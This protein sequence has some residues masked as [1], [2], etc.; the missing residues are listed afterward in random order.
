MRTA[1]VTVGYVSNER[2]TANE[3][4]DLRAF[5]RAVGHFSGTRALTSTTVERADPEH[6]AE[7]LDPGPSEICT[8]ALAVNAFVDGIQAALVVTHRGHRPVYLNYAAAG[9][10]ALDGSPVALAEDLWVTSS[11]SDREWVDG[12]GSTI[13]I[14]TLEAETP[15][16]VE[17]LGMDSLAGHRSHLERSVVAQLQ[18][19][20][21]AAVVLDGALI[22]RE[23]DRRLFGVV[24]STARK[25]LADEGCLFGLRTGWRSPRFVIPAGPAGSGV[26]R[27]SCYVRLH[28]ASRHHWNFALIRLECFEDPDLLDPLAARCL[29]E[30]QPPTA[31][32]A[33][34]DRHLRS[35]RATEDFLRARRPAVFSMSQ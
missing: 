35:V 3:P 6:P 34:W 30:R 7:V 12:L 22:G 21:A 10:L 20:G 9:A 1:G 31:A 4:H 27:Y 17:R 23:Q 29:L 13:P 14:E 33:R 15:P 5:F 8:D 32:D 28:D 19:A 11:S 18:H 2:T 16:E 26:A 24:K 25:Y